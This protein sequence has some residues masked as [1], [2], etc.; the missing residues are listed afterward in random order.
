M[1]LWKITAQSVFVS[2]NSFPNFLTPFDIF[3]PL[4]QNQ[5]DLC[6]QTLEQ[7]LD[8]GCL[9]CKKTRNHHQSDFSKKVGLFQFKKTGFEK[10]K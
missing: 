5:F 4:V 6:Q 3:A 1:L 2:S 10:K 7:C 9:C 8:I